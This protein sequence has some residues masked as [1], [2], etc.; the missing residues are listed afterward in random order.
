MDFAET[1]QTLGSP[2][3]A[4][5]QVEELQQKIHQYENQLQTLK[6]NSKEEISRKIISELEDKLM[7]SEK[8]RVK[9]KQQKENL[10]I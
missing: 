5:A 4:Q 2:G 7:D 10:Q 6:N 1:L 9:L 8:N 3:Y